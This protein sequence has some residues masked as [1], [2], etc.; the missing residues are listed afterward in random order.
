MLEE[1]GTVERVT[2]FLEQVKRKE[3]RLLGFGHRVYKSYDPR[4]RLVRT[5][6]HRIFQV[7]G[8]EPL[9]HVA[10][11]LERQA[12]YDDYFI[13]R[14]LYP[15]VDF[16][17]G[18]CYKAMGFPPTFSPSCL[19]CRELWDGWLIG[20][21]SWLT[22]LLPVS[23][24]LVNGMMSFR[25]FRYV[26][27]KE[28]QPYTPLDGRDKEDYCKRP[29]RSNSQAMYKRYTISRYHQTGQAHFRASPDL[30]PMRTPKGNK[31][32]R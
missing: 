26:G 17:T 6:L 20:G 11:A 22:W 27:P 8:Q 12:L 24:D 21:S 30:P 14:R 1:I 7:C 9:M 23:G 13:Q 2:E 4:A 15:N 16:Y 3:R 25:V 31:E 18:L 19:Q 28:E 5:I 29:S 32:D 10:E